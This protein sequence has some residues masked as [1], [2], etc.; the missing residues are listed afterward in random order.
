MQNLARLLV[1]PVVFFG[2][3]ILRQQPQGLL[4]DARMIREHLPRREETVAAEQGDEPGHSRGEIGLVPHMRAQ[5]PQAAERSFYELVQGRAVTRDLRDM[6]Y[7]GAR[8][9]FE[10]RLQPREIHRIGLRRP[11]WPLSGFLD[12]EREI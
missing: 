11:R 5:D 9:L 7:P 6:P 12:H 1:A 10:R 8:F 2:P 3:L 4:G